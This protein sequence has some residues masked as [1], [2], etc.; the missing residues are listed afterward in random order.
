[1]KKVEV[2]A[3]VLKHN[4][5]FFCAQRKD[6]GTLAKKWEFPGGKLEQGETREEALKRELQEELNLNTIIGDYIMTVKHQYPTFHITMH[7]FYCDINTTDITLNEH[8]D[9]KW[10]TVDELKGLD[11]AEADIPIVDKIILENKVVQ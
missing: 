11:W 8:L 4:N 1:M 10:L 3:A 6:A 2:V 7:A 9:S 5:K